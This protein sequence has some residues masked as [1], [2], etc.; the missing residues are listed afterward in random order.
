MAQIM[1]NNLSHYLSTWNLSDPQLLAQTATSH[2]YTVALDGTR[3]VLKLL[4]PLGEKDERFGAI[5]LRH[6][7]GRGAVRLL[8]DDAHA[9]LL[10]YASG[11][12]LVT[13]VE[14]G[15]DH[16]ATERIVEVL[17][18][19]HAPSTEPLPNT[20]RTLRS[21]FRALFEK[22][23]ADTASGL[24]SPFVRAARLADELLND[25][26]DVRVLHGDIHHFNIRHHPQRGWL[27]F[28]PK[29]LVGERTYDTANTLCNPYNF[30][31]LVFNEQRM[32][33]TAGILADGL[34]IDRW[35]VLAFVFVYVCLSASWYL[36]DG[37]RADRDLQIA[38][39]VEPHLKR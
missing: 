29:G 39:L 2:V 15:E 7:N 19:M 30:P 24:D 26:R 37:E 32:L 38:A 14:Q 12:H 5:A 9:Q 11:E 31:E 17:N 34:G 3:A 1:T 35:R 18:A 25:P 8:R 20:L 21:W 28:D 36:E 10:E 27:A 4:T 13:L 22:A 6:W 33:T 16:R 23:A